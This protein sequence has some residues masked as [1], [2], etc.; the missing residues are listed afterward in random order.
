MWSQVDVSLRYLVSYAHQG[1]ARVSCRDGCGCAAHVI[2]AHR[3]AFR[4]SVQEE[5]AFRVEMAPPRASGAPARCT[6]RVEVLPSSASGEHELK[7]YGLTLQEA[8]TL[9][10]DR[11]SASEQPLVE[12]T[13]H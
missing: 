9:T 5:D 7:L 11:A 1:T 2:N 6:L 3:P 4:E 8:G 13:A 10:H 12:T